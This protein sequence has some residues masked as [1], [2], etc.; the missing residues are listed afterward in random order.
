M[1]QQ[2]GTL[3]L[4]GRATGITHFLL[5]ATY[6]SQGDK[7]LPWS[8][9]IKSLNWSQLWLFSYNLSRGL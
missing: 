1:S 9:T 7:M 4:L 6:I 2:L 3:V 8:S 5:I